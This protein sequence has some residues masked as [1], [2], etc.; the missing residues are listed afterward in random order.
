MDHHD[1]IFKELTTPADTCPTLTFSTQLRTVLAIETISICL[2]SGIAQIPMILIL[3]AFFVTSFFTYVILDGT[4]ILHRVAYTFYPYS[5]GRVLSKTVL[6]IY[7]GLVGALHITIIA[8]TIS[9]LCGYQF[10]PQTMKRFFTHGPLSP[11][12]VWMNRVC[13]HVFGLTGLFAYVA[14]CVYLFARGTLRFGNNSEIRLTLQV[15]VMSTIGMFYF[16]YFEFHEMLKIPQ[17]AATIIYET[18]VLLYY[19]SE[20]AP[21]LLLNKKDLFADVSQLIAYIRRDMPRQDCIRSTAVIARDQHVRSI[22]FS[23]LCLQL[24]KSTSPPVKRAAPAKTINT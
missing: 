23:P 8:L 20:F 12:L 22:V 9:P 24:E 16:S 17:P 11:F 1:T 13:N 4:L 10:C 3:G 21:Y 2:L 19:N 5:A 7:L 15:I 14:I 18:V 6:E